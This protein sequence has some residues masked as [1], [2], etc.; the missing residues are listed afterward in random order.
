MNSGLRP[1]GSRSWVP[2]AIVLATVLL[3][4]AEAQTRFSRLEAF[5][6]RTR[7]IDVHSHPSSRHVDFPGDDTYP[8]LEPPIGRPYWPIPK[9]RIAVFDS[10]EPAALRAI[11]GFPGTDVTEKDLPGLRALSRKFWEVGG[12]AGLDRVLDICGIERTLANAD[13]PP[14]ADPARVGWVPFA[15]SFLYPL[16]ASGIKNVPPRLQEI[17]EAA[18]DA[19]ARRL[20]ASGRSAVHLGAYLDFVGAALEAWK[21]RGAAALKLGIAY[22]R[23]LQFDD[24]SWEEAAAVYSEGRQGTLDSWARYKILQDVIARRVFLKA[25]EIG[26]PVHIHT[27]FGADARL[28]LADSNPL[29]LES[30]VADLRYRNTRF[31]ILHAGYPFWKELNPLLE[32]RN[33]FVDFSAVNWMVFEDE[34]AGILGGWL[35]YPGAAEKIMF[36]SDAGAPVFFWMA[37]RNSRQALYRALA[38]LIDRGVITEDQAM[39]V[40]G[41]VMRDNALRIHNLP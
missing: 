11:Y 28:K 38:G 22:E 30:V 4:R 39:L 7:F 27:G 6:S 41:K 3:P 8:T 35:A 23:T 10:L 36:G 33:V 25:G 40:A 15:D 17:V 26:L 5:I 12:P 24:P 32:K 37:A 34:L 9:E 29:N 13:E 31:V 18:A 2:A 20:A 21:R 16:A 1:K 14:N 19:V